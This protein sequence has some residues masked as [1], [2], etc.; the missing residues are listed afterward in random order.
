MWTDGTDIIL[1]NTDDQYAICVAALKAELECAPAMV[2][3][4]KDLRR[5]DTSCQALTM[6]GKLC[7]ATG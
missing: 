4:L 2:N 5:V 7:K 3:A 6:G 1:T